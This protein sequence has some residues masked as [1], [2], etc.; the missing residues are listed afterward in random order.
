MI[1]TPPFTLVYI[2]GF[3]SSPASHKARQLQHWLDAEQ[4]TVQYA[5][6]SLSPFPLEAMAQLTAIVQN[7][8]GRVGLIGSSLGGFYAAYLA[9]RFQLPAVLINP[10]VRPF[11]TLSR[12]LGENENFYTQERYELTQQHVDDLQSLFV[13]RPSRPQQLWLMVQTADETLDY[14]EA[15]THYRHSPAVIEYGGNHSFE[16]IERF[17]TPILAFLQTRQLSD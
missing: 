9:E 8:P 12:Y 4:P 13:E 5:I 10:A 2:H 1:N 7:A 11:D 15:T 14:R 17:F 3:N 16:A 6:P